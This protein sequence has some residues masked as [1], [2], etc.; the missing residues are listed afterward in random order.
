[1]SPDRDD[2]TKDVEQ[3][4][5]RQGDQMED[6]LGKL[7]EHI[8]EARKKA[9]VTRKQSDLD[10]EDPTGVAGDWDD[11]QADDDDPS[12]AVDDEAAQER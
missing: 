9:Q 10:R 4:L 12:G 5:D 8:E 2:R 11:M 7:D 3:A 1:M 6:R